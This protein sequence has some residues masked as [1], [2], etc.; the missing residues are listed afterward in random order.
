MNFSK[1]HIK[2]IMLRETWQDSLKIHNYR[3]VYF[4]IA[5]NYC[6]IKEYYRFSEED[7]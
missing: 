4:M 6:N 1:K 5:R 3:F 2:L 7:V